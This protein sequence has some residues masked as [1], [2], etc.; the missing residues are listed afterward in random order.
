MKDLAV[1]IKELAGFLEV[2]SFSKKKL[3]EEEAQIFRNFIHSTAEQLKNEENRPVHLVFSHGDF[4]PANLLRAK[5]GLRIV[6]WESI[7]Y[8]NM[9]FDFFSY[10]F[11]RPVSPMLPV[12]TIVSEINEALPF[13]VSKIS[14]KELNINENLLS[15]VN[16][17]RRLYYIERLYMLVER[18][19][20]DC[21]LN[22]KSYIFRYIDAYSSYENKLNTG[23]M[24]Y[25]SKVAS[26]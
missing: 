18:D 9:L 25:N 15:L 7:R 13:F 24:A 8:R 11:Y 16:I 6:D 12:D 21:R 4:C 2:N 20:T 19:N 1:Y 26:A 10:F 22:M 17:Y 14:L 3:N 23:A 5:D